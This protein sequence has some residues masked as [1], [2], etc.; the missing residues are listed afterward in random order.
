MHVIRPGLPLLTAFVLLLSAC[1]ADVSPVSPDAERRGEAAENAVVIP[2]GNPPATERLDFD[3]PGAAALREQYGL[4]RSR[5]A[6][7]LRQEGPLAQKDKSVQEFLESTSSSP[8]AP[9]LEQ[10]ASH[11]MLTALLDEDS[12]NVELVGFYTRILVRNDN[13]DAEIIHRA[14]RHL[15]E[16]WPK[17]DI[18]RAT[19]STVRHALRWAERVCPN[20]AG[21]SSAKVSPD[22]GVEAKRRGILDAVQKLTEPVGP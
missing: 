10:Y 22:A 6:G 19:T 13:P 11:R 14:L 5:L 12:P 21:A 15:G 16:T 8:L 20:C 17:A 1:D 3:S 2:Y 18:R 7:L 9:Y 4:T